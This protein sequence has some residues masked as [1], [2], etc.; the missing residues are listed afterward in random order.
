MKEKPLILTVDRNRRNVELLA[1]FLTKEG[2]QSL[3][4]NTL[5]EFEQALSS[6]SDK[7]NFVLVDVAGFDR[8]I[9]ELCQRL[10]DEQIPFVVISPR[11]SAS[12]QQQ[13]LAHGAWS[14]L[15]KPLVVKELLGLIR[16]LLGDQV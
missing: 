8:S 12:I 16:S 10:Q 4:A 13:S 14:M 15:V 1:Q 5:E 3:G 2:Y 9:W 7:I 11:Q 6:T